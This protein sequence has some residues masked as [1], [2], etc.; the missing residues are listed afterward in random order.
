M[1]GV[2]GTLL[3][4]RIAY[5]R[6]TGC[7]GNL[8]RPDVRVID[9]WQ[10]KFKGHA[11]AG[12]GIYAWEERLHACTLALYVN[13]LAANG[14]GREIDAARKRHIKWCLEKHLLAL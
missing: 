9:H 6:Q 8:Q 4:C 13:E 1:I 7:G 14:R 2:N 11:A 3:T 5:L 10:R 12:K